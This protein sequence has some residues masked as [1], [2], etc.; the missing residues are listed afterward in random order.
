ML[1]RSLDKAKLDGG[2]KMEGFRRLDRFV[3]V[4]ERQMSPVADFDATLQHEHAISP[5][6]NGRTV[7]DD[8]R[9]EPRSGPQQ[10]SLWD[11]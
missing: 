9:P 3:K 4:I 7:F 11:P 1:R 10:M 5:A 8:K 6:L 2:A